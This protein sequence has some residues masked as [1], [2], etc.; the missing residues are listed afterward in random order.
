DYE[1]NDISTTQQGD[2][3][4][5]C[6]DCQNTTGCK[7]YNWDS[8]VCYLKSK[9]GQVVSAPGSV[10][11]FISTPKPI[12]TAPTDG[13]CSV[14]KDVDFQDFDIKTTYHEDA[15]KCCADCQATEGCKV[16]TWAN[17]ACYLKSKKGAS[18][19]LPGAIS[20]VQSSKPVPTS[21][22]TVAPTPTPTTSGT[23]STQKDVDFYGSDIKTTYQ[24]EAT[25]CCADCQATEGCKV[26]T[27][28][29]GACYLKSKQGVSS[30][31]SGAISGVLSANSAPTSK[32]TLAPTSAPTPVPT[33]A[34]TPAPTLTL[35]EGAIVMGVNRT[36]CLESNGAVYEPYLARC[37]PSPRQAWTWTKSL[38]LYNAYANA[39]LDHDS[40]G[41][42]VYLWS[43]HQSTSWQVNGLALLSSKRPTLAVS[44]DSNG[45]SLRAIQS[46]DDSQVM[47]LTLVPTLPTRATPLKGTIAIGSNRS[48]CLEVPNLQT[49]WTFEPM[50]TP[51]REDAQVQQWEWVNATYVYNPLTKM[52][53]TREKNNAFSGTKIK[54]AACTSTDGQIWK[55]DGTALVHPKFPTLVLEMPFG[56]PGTLEYLANGNDA[57]M[58]DLTQVVSAAPIPTP[59]PTLAPTPIPTVGRTC[60]TKKDVDFYGSDIK[61]TYQD[62]ATKCCADCEA[63]EGCKVYTW[64]NGACYLKSKQGASSPFP[65]AISGVLSQQPTL[66]PTSAPNLPPVSGG[67]ITTGVGECL[68]YN[69]GLMRVDTA[70]CNGSP[71]QQWM[72][73]KSLYL[74]N[75]GSDDCLDYMTETPTERG[76]VTFI[77]CML[78]K[79]QAWQVRGHAL[80]P[81][82]APALALSFEW[83]VSLIERKNAFLKAFTSSDSTQHMDLTKVP[84]IPTRAAAFKGTIA[85]GANRSYCL[86]ASTKSYLD[87]RGAPCNDQV[88]AQQWMWVNAKYLYNPATKQCLTLFMGNANSASVIRTK[89]CVLSRAQSWQVVGNAV[90]NEEFPG[91]AVSI[92]FAGLVFYNDVASDA[93]AQILDL[94]QVP[95]APATLPTFPPS[96]STLQGQLF[97]GI[98]RSFCLESHSTQSYVATCDATSPEQMYTWTRETKKL[99]SNQY[100]FDGDFQGASILARNE[101]DKCLAVQTSN[102]IGLGQW[103]GTKPC[104]VLDD[105]QLFSFAAV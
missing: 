30:P 97:V 40:T 24:D 48:Y 49:T 29:N 27:W 68:G 33:P 56:S 4:G 15:T 21:K 34:P 38:R 20:G 93:D 81:T 45:A 42:K 62:D 88:P 64:V 58:L 105:T 61:T 14:V 71:N 103:L 76:K 39:C 1:G 101:E 80:V 99:T 18:S 90:V 3:S 85:V 13:A 98:N 6:A 100:A 9:K 41:S 65:G 67:A 94:T 26:Y 22:P 87:P 104:D 84:L 95:S 66:P 32:P 19:P 53:L 54:V 59:Q 74:Y 75:V 31:F 69:Q 2:P 51:C 36:L 47:N 55:V 37:N 102:S 52:C 5:C 77:G 60:S 25:K 44:I 83:E 72:W 78:T 46:G 11:G 57:Q 10:S 23:C 96:V 50:G 86:E 28:A 8:G 16:Y 91:Q 70:K 79:S 89:T 17:G 92:G 63:T 7:A 82:T 43:C 12:T 73:Y 35:F